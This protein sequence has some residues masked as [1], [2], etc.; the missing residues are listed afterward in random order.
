M[1]CSVSKLTNFQCGIAGVRLEV[2]HDD[3]GALA[4]EDSGAGGAD[5]ARPA[6]HQGDLAAQ[7]GE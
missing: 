4:G 2:R 7:H 5:A 6:R 3:L 1:I